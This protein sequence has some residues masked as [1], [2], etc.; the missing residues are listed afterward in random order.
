MSATT[1]SIKGTG[2][3]KNSLSKHESRGIECEKDLKQL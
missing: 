1:Q 2:K 3:M